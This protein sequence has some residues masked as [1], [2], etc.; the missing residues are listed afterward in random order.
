MTVTTSLNYKEY[1]AD[2]QATVFAIPFLLLARN[3]LKV[4][5]DNTPITLDYT[6]RGIGNPV[7]E[8]IFSEAP[9]GR[10]LLQR[11]VELVRE[12]DYQ[13]NGDLL[14]KTINQDFDRIYLAMQGM[15]QDN[16][17]ALRVLD[18]EGIK[19]LPLASERANKT[20]SFDT[21]GQPM[22]ATIETGS[23][24]DLA[25]KLADSSDQHKGASLVGY[26]D[27]LT[28]PNKTVG[29]KLNNLT[30]RCDYFE[31]NG[32]P[33]FSVL[34]WPSRASIPAGYVAADGQQLSQAAYPDI[35]EA[36][37]RGDVP[38]VA[39]IEWQTDPTKRGSYVATSSEGQFRIPDYNGKYADSLGALFL[40]GDNGTVKNGEI[41]KDG[42]GD[43]E[44]PITYT[45]SDN[46]LS[47]RWWNAKDKLSCGI[48]MTGG[49]WN[50]I[51]ATWKIINDFNRINLGTTETRPIN[52][53]GCWIIKLFTSAINVTEANI[54]QLIT[55]NANLLARLSRLE[56]WQQAKRFT[57][58]YPNGGTAEK[59][60]NVETNKRYE[61]A[62]PFQG[63]SIN[64]QAE[65][66]VNGT[67][68]ITGW[69]VNAGGYGVS[70]GHLLESDTIIIQT[71]LKYICAGAAYGGS[72]LSDATNISTAPCRIK[73]WRN[74]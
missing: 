9:S 45:A 11:T 68:G 63:E 19:A 74:V 71:G 39:E 5:L 49:G 1:Q 18:P 73:V 55:D 4:F 38:T 65:I 53:T 56:S 23:A 44:I 27:N 7:S 26:N 67:W 12:T 52:V 48:D 37:Q 3:D 15:A 14:A 20:L 31:G 22:L 34:W 69:Y 58:I 6:I 17:K 46:A 21:V 42:L 66:L 35:A 64:C 28:Y 70:V 36:I 24:T 29:K 47:A 62:N 59:P 2:G 10:L 72:I 30:E 57:I 61:I 33:A 43:A 40:R 32:V 8:I 13:E 51:T 41:Q 54:Q 16:T 60:A 25:K 50:G